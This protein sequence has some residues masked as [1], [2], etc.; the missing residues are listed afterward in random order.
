MLGVTH[1]V[2]VPTAPITIV[3]AGTYAII[4]SV[5]G[6]EPN[7]FTL[8]INGAPAPSTTYGSGAGTQQNTGL[9]ILTLGTGDIITLV[10]HSS[11]AAVGLAS[12]VGGTEAN[13]SAS[14]LIER[15]A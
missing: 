6:T 12:V 1:S 3:N 14:V 13:V 5:S 2:I 4:F 9:S 15:L 10:N 7:Q 11:A 8:Y